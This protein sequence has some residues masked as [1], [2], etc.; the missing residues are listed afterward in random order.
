[1]SIYFSKDINGNT[2]VSSNSGNVQINGI[3]TYTN[4]TWLISSTGGDANYSSSISVWGQN[5]ATN[6][7]S[8]FNK[9][10]TYGNANSNAWNSSTGI[11]TIPQEGLYYFVINMY[12]NASVA[13]KWAK[14]VFTST[15]YP[16][17]SFMYLA[18]NNANLGTDVNRS[19][20]Y[21]RYMDAGDTF[22]IFVETGSVRLYLA[23][24]HTNFIITKIA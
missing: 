9:V 7:T 19:W 8:Y 4:P 18:F 11:F 14:A 5:T 2:V 24:G 6:P 1:M 21:M 10:T 17:P 20:S 22:Y 15:K 13:G 3:I 23:D 16:T 12:I